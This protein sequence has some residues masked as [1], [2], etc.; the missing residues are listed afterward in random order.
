MRT[1]VFDVMCD[2]RFITQHFYRWCPAFKLNFEEVLN[3][4]ISERPSLK[5]KHLELFITED[6]V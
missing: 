5:G 2:G 4:V 6:V 3:E 1:I